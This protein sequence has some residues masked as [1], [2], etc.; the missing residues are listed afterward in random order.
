MNQLHKSKHPP[1]VRINT[2]M[3]DIDTLMQQW[4]TQVE[5]KLNDAQLDLS[6]LDCELPNLVDIVCNLIDVPVQP[7]TRIESL[8]TLFT[9]FLEVRNISDRN[10]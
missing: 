8:H 1:S 9:L 10:F 2:Q 4:P 7:D 5:D 6:K 3:P